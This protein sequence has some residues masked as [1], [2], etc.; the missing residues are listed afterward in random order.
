MDSQSVCWGINKSLNG[1]DGNKKIKGIKRHI[2]VDKNDFLIAVMV[3][4]ANIHN[5]KAALLLMR[6]IKEFLCSIKV[7]LADGAYRGE[8]AQ[9]VKNKFKQAL[10]EIFSLPIK[11]K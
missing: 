11:T 6:I 9:E 5:S 4:V 8:L 2:I 7:I 3:T 10:K 1:F